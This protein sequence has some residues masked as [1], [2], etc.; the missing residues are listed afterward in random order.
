M[1]LSK[2]GW[3]KATVHGHYMV[4]MCACS[5][6]TKNIHSHKVTIHGVSKLTC[7][8]ISQLMANN[9]GI[10]IVPG[11]ITNCAPGIT[12]ANLNSSFIGNTSTNQS[13]LSIGTGCYI[14]RRYIVDYQLALPNCLHNTITSNSSII[15]VTTVIW[16]LENGVA[17]TLEKL[18]ISRWALYIVY[19]N[20][21]SSLAKVG[22]SICLSSW[23]RL[24]N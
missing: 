18:G 1:Y 7:C 3:G 24:S 10:Q 9:C 21:A 4:C 2:L 8:W 23:K 16:N 19:K 20:G 5:T 14:Q 15:I 13:Q 17:W 11:I 6:Y 12:R 22:I